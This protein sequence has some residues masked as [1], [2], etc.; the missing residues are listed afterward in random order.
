MELYFVLEIVERREAPKLFDLHKGMG[1]SLVL[2]NLA[3]GTATYE[4]LSLY[5]LEPSEKIVVGTVASRETM[6]NLFKKARQEFYIDI[7]G[8]GIILAIP[9]KSIGGQKTLAYLT[10]NQN[11]GGGTPDM[12]F[13]H[14][15]IV[16]I[17]NEGYADSVMEAARSAGATGGTLVHAKGAG[18]SQKEKFF[19]V[20]LAEE[21]DMLYIV[22]D[23]ENKAA[24]MK[25]IN[26]KC[27]EESA[28]EAICF[29]L[30]VSQ[31]EGLRRRE[32]D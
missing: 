19:D 27:G 11:V 32:E 18:K 24:I 16:V 14:E 9:M 3:S 4:H 7:P 25:A 10:E 1:L 12:K 31:A 28:V 8:R 20:S 26:E 23:S 6:R 22:A 21:K 13:E 29:S 30:P 17:L 2:A 5:D 15:L